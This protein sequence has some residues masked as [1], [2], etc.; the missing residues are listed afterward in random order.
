MFILFFLSI[1]FITVKVGNNLLFNYTRPLRLGAP[2][3]E[4]MNGLTYISIV[5]RRGKARLWGDIYRG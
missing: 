4:F 3:N 2:T 5:E 1:M